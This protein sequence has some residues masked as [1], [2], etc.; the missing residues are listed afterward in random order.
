MWLQWGHSYKSCRNYLTMPYW[1]NSVSLQWGYSPFGCRDLAQLRKVGSKIMWLQWGY[2]HEGCRDESVYKLFQQP[3]LL[4]W[5]YSHKDCRD[6]S[7]PNLH[8][9]T[10]LEGLLREPGSSLRQT[11][12]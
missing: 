9:S 12:T 4:Q 5:G 1:L 11:A 6:S 2:S 7:P 8:N 10:P 3:T